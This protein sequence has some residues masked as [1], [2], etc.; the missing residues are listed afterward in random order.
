MCEPLCQKYY[1]YLHCAYV[2]NNNNQRKKEA[3][4][5]RG[6]DKWKSLRKDK[7]DG[8]EGEKGGESGIIPFWLKA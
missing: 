7:R 1:L 4:S 8:L 5:L 2:C 3:I 6:G